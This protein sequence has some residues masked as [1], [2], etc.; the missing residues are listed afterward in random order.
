MAWRASTHVACAAPGRDCIRAWSFSDY[1]TFYRF[2]GCCWRFSS[3]PRDEELA[4]R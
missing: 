3:F 2:R 4:S 1:R